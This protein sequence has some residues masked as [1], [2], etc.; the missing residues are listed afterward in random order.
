MKVWHIV[1]TVAALFAVLFGLSLIFAS[2]DR[3]YGEDFTRL[4]PAVGEALPHVT[5]ILCDEQGQIQMIY[6]NQVSGGIEGSIQ[7]YTLLQSTPNRLGEP[8]CF[9]GNYGAG[10]K[11]KV[12]EVVPL[13]TI[14]PYTNAQGEQTLP[15]EA[16]AIKVDW[17][18]AIGMGEGWIMWVSSAEV[19]DMAPS[20]NMS[21][22][23]ARMATAS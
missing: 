10:G 15:K 21:L 2:Y 22:Q 3:S 19:D 1:V 7:A 12:V 13:G 16:W 23:G 11:L 9:M 8:T 20:G 6:D 17:D 4:P 18:D 14:P 5:S